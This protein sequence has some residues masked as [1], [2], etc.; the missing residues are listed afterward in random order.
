MKKRITVTLE[1]DFS[2]LRVAKADIVERI[3]SEEGG[4]SLA[5]L[6][7][8]LCDIQDQAAKRVGDVAVFGT[9]FD[10]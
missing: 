6:A 7:S 3:G 2:L 8:L 10:P 5:Y 9:M 4:T 1:I